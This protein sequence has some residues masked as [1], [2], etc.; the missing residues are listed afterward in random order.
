MF[1][2]LTPRRPLPSLNG[3]R[4]FEA[5]GRTGGATLAA[6]ELCVT[7]SAVS[8]QVKM[9]E[10]SLGVRLFEGPRHRLR[11]TARGH[12]LLAGL[13]PGFDALDAAV[14]AVRGHQDVRLAVHPSLAVKWL[15]PRLADFERRHEEVVLDL[16]ELPP[17]AS[18]KRGA[19]V[20][21]RYLDAAALDDPSVDVLVKNLVGLVHAPGLAPEAVA[22]APRLTAAT[23][24]E[25]WAEW[26]T[27]SGRATPSGPARTLTHLHMVL[28]A[29][30]AGL[31]VAVLPWTIVADDVK[32]R[33]L[34]APFGFVP[35][36]GALAAI[37][38][39][40]AANRGE[41]VLIR[42]L[43]EQAGANPPVGA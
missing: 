24:A 10:I 20:L 6:A 1:E 15:I 36:G 8:R 14:H 16:S 2:K 35:D 26:S 39:N 3:L 12:A 13:S 23:R 41:R 9:L 5:M 33:R 19:D 17:H 25:A 31:G 30:A 22:T 18:R 7:H 38:M 32:A 40:G 42:W 43:R 21:L 4:A 11:L 34:T 29:A 37:R 28:D 27:A